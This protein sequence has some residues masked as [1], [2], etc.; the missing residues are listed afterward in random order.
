MTMTIELLVEKLAATII[1]FHNNISIVAK[2]LSED[3][4]GLLITECRRRA[5]P[6]DTRNFPIPEWDI[7]A[8]VLEKDL[9]MRDIFQKAKTHIDA[10]GECYCVHCRGS[11][12]PEHLAE[13]GDHEQCR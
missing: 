1:E 8:D 5:Q 9:W 3:D 10:T 4:L 13:L 6:N 2:E 7:I 12:T 11:C